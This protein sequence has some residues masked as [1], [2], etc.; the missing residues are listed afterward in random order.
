MNKV[1]ITPINSVIVS[2]N[3]SGTE[4]TS[5]TSSNAVFIIYEVDISLEKSSS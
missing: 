5:P 1:I 4:M 3:K 2:N